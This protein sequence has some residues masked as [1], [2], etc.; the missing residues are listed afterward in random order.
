MARRNLRNSNKLVIHRRRNKSLTNECQALSVYCANLKGENTSFKSKYDLLLARVAR[1][2]A[3]AKKP[4]KKKRSLGS[5]L[6]GFI[7][8]IAA[9]LLVVFLVNSVSFTLEIPN[10]GINGIVTLSGNPVAPEDFLSDSYGMEGIGA[11]FYS[12]GDIDFYRG[13]R[14]EIVLVLQMGRRTAET[15]TVLYVLEPLRY[16]EMEAGTPS[17][18]ITPAKFLPAAYIVN[19]D[20]AL[21][22]AIHGGLP[23]QD[24]LEVGRHTITVSVNGVFF[25]SEVNIVDT[26]PPT[27]T[28]TNVTIPMGQDIELDD[29]ILEYFDI[30]PIVDIWFVEEP[31]VFAPGNQTVS[32]GFK[33]YFGN[34]AIYSAILTVH[35]NTIPPQI[36]GTQDIIVQIGTPIIY[37]I[38]VSAEDAF[39][40][41]LDFN[42]DSSNVNIHELGTYTAIYYAIDAWGLRTEAEIH[43]T[44]LEVD[45]ERVR[46]LAQAVLDN[47]LSGN[48]TQVQEARA[49]FDWIQN[50]VAYAANISQ[51]SVYEGAYQALRNRRGDCFVFYSVSQVLLT[52]AGIPNMHIQ[53]IETAADRHSWNLINPDELGWHHFDATPLMP[54][55]EQRLNRFMFTSSQARRHTQLIHS[56]LGTRDY[57]TY[58]SELLPEIVQ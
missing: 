25:D 37:R 36:F 23:E 30:S 1:L 39:G 50:N 43:V 26:T 20:T 13:G 42:V 19:A 7:A 3:V 57:Y 38:G 11:E 41:P 29:F 24:I 51:G 47:I 10:D 53:R 40:R 31:Y 21:D 34:Q 14:H 35:P 2:E 32:I 55:G 18:Y 16:V 46:D 44:V 33:D 28:L 12:P 54:V 15:T 52:V 27:A 45:P 6:I 4:Q 48:M 8:G 17:S 22:I 56:Y 49:I 58:D 9:T 5:Y